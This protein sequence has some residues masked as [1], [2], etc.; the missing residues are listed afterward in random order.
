MNS[1]TSSVL[2]TAI[3]GG[4]EYDLYNMYFTNTSSVRSLFLT[5]YYYRISAN[6]NVTSTSNVRIFPAFNLYNTSITS[7]TLEAQ[8]FIIN[9]STTS[10]TENFLFSNSTQLSNLS[11][12][13][14]MCYSYSRSNATGISTYTNYI[15]SG[16]AVG[17]V[18]T[19]SS[20]LLSIYATFNLSSAVGVGLS[21]NSTGMTVM[22]GSYM[23]IYPSYNTFVGNF[24]S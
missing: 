19:A 11:T 16:T 3:P 12:F 14:F 1:S 21:M 20:G 6:I 24:S 23:T 5:P 13:N 4:I 18:T 22:P 2:T 15:T 17:G 8:I 7:Y 10:R 9:T